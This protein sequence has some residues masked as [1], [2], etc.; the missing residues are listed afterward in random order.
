V[1]PFWNERGIS[2]P[3]LPA[4]FFY[5]RFGVVL[6]A[7]YLAFLQMSRGASRWRFRKKGHSRRV[8]SIRRVSLTR[9]EC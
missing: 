3:T 8:S 7:I 6:L 4:N 5:P 2:N 1:Q 9:T